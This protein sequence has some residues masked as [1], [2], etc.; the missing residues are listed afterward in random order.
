MTS[1]DPILEEVRGQYKAI[2]EGLDNLQG[3][4]REMKEVKKRL[5]GVE[6]GVRVIK[7]SVVDHSSLIAD[8]EDRLT[9]LEQSV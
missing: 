8:H 5:E 2:Q 9:I 6:R 4:P 1:K 3:L 7:K